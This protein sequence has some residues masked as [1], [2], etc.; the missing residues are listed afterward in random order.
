MEREDE[1]KKQLE[2]EQ[3]QA[4]IANIKNRTSLSPSP[5]KKMGAG[6]FEDDD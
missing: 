3:K 4:K 5:N 6:A 2:I 1:L